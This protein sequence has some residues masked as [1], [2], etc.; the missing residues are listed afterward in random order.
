MD[1]VSFSDAI[2]KQ[3]RAMVAADGKA[4][5]KEAERTGLT[6]D[7][8]IEQVEKPA[9]DNY[10]SGASGA[11]GLKALEAGYTAVIKNMEKMKEIAGIAGD[12]DAQ[13]TDKDRA[14]FQK[15]IDYCKDKINEI[16]ENAKDTIGWAPSLP[17][18][19][20]CKRFGIQDLSVMTYLQ[21]LEADELIDMAVAEAKVAREKSRRMFDEIEENQQ[22]EREKRV[23]D[24]LDTLEQNAQQ[25]KDI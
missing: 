17:G 1:T 2:A 3:L 19:M 16:D 15:E 18:L 20:D 22:A 8:A 4:V 14:E 11:A 23:E 10:V 21:S 24:A 5:D 12:P 9:E 25:M 7:E 6:D 13:L